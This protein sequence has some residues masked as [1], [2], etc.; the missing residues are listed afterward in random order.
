MLIISPSEETKSI[1]CR[2]I[3]IQ[4]PVALFEA[5]SEYKYVYFKAIYVL[6]Q[7]NET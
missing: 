6:N 1:R 5:S 7:E 4:R 2:K 3:V